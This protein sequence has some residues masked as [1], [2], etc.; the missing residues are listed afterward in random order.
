MTDRVTRDDDATPNDGAP[1]DDTTPNDA[2]LNPA[3]S[4]DRKIRTGIDVIRGNRAYQI[5]LAATTCTVLP[6]NE[7]RVA[8]RKIW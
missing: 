7:S 1:N 3:T 4:N 2:T 5:F 8:T 6:A